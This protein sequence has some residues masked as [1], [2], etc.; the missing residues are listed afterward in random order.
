M[1]C[2]HAHGDGVEAEEVGAGV[3]EQKRDGGEAE[4]RAQTASA[5]GRPG[6]AS[7]WVCPAPR[8]QY[9]RGAC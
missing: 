9:S 2:Q 5:P 8:V 4:L 7:R 6:P 3:P 1:A